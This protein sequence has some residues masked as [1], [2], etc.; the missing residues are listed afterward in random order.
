MV[1]CHQYIGDIDTK[2]ISV[3]LLYNV[4][5]NTTS[6]SRLVFS[7]CYLHMLLIVEWIYN[8]N[9]VDWLKNQ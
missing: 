3:D 9:N 1:L 4:P 2:M 8:A 5:S 7:S 6:H